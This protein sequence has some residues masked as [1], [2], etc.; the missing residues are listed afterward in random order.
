MWQAP[1]LKVCA[2]SDKLLCGSRLTYNRLEPPSHNMDPSKAAEIWVSGPP[3]PP[4]KKMYINMGYKVVGFVSTTCPRSVRLSI[5]GL[6][7]APRLNLSKTKDTKPHEARAMIYTVIWVTSIY[8]E[9][10]RRSIYIYL[11]DI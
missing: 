4:Y 10:Y 7:D 2:R 8:K 5:Q 9:V 1:V 3:G 6:G 11:L